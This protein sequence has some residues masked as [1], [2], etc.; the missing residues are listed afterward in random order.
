MRTGFDRDKG[1][2]SLLLLVA[3]GCVFLSGCQRDATLTGANIRK[4]EVRVVTDQGLVLDEQATPTQVAFVLLRAIRD[5]VRA[6]DTDAREKALQ[7]QFALCAPETI[8]QAHYQYYTRLIG[9]YTADRDETVY[10]VVRSWAP[11][12]ARYV[13]AFDFDWPA[14]EQR[15][16]QSA[17]GKG[18]SD[19]NE[20]SS[21]LVEAA[22]PNGDPNASVVIKIDLTRESGFWRVRWIGFWRKTRHLGRSAPSTSAPSNA[23]TDA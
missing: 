11:R 19:G 9:S 23:E 7:R 8:Y 3:A 22:D 6:A 1:S 21:V 16:V 17:V 5:Q 14:A 10:R 12:V 13:G 4:A 15:L 20:I 18:A 2:V